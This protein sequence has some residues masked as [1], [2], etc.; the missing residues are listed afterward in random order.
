MPFTFKAAPIE[1]LVVVEPWRFEDERGFFMET[2][3][4]SDFRAAGIEVD[5]VQDNHSRSTKGVLRGL[6]FQTGSSAQEKLVRVVSGS[7][8][9]VA[10]DLRNGSS[11]YGKWW[12]LELSG[13]NGLMLF[14]PRGFAHGFVTLSEEAHLAY[15]CTAEYDKERDGGVRWDDPRL[16]IGWPRRDVLVSAKDA[17]LPYLKDLSI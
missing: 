7:V 9:D 2:Y 6:H 17:A 3:R 8:W 1:G 4:R 14:I 11:S 5:F 10:V 16:E 13:E 12:G 15:K